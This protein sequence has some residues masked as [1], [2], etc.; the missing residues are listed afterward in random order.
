MCIGCYTLLFFI[1]S[2]SRSIARRQ[3]ND[4]TCKKNGNDWAI[5]KNILIL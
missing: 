2:G 3:I 5:A 4:D 1:N